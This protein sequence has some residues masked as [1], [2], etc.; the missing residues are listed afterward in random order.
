[1]P[2]FVNKG[3]AISGGSMT[4]AKAKAGSEEGQAKHV[5]LKGGQSY[6]LSA[7]GRE[8]LEFLQTYSG[9]GMKGT[10]PAGAV[11]YSRQPRDL[12]EKDG[13][14]FK[15]T[16]VRWVTSNPLPGTLP[17]DMFKLAQAIT[18]DLKGGKLVVF[19]AAEYAVTQSDYRGF[20]FMAQLMYDILPDC[21]GAL[22]LSVDEK[23]LGEQE[24]HMLMRSA[25][26]NE[27]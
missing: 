27:L 16:D 11:L 23:A 13:Y 15:D 5:E 19:D 2:E 10:F 18:T 1:M 9:N 20:L 3:S 12:L 4:V 6:F 17:P 25:E 8:A 24:S 7:E 22:V 26:L 21:S 14:H